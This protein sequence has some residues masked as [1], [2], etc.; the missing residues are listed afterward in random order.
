M[1]RLDQQPR[2]QMHRRLA[3]APQYPCLCGGDPP[4]HFFVRM[5][6]QTFVTMLK[7]R[8]IHSVSDF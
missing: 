2:R 4:F 7:R 3:A 1:E 5:L 8:E 6:T